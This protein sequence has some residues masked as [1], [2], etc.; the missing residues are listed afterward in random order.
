[1]CYRIITVCH[2]VI[3]V[4]Q[5]IFTE[6]YCV[7]TA[8]QHIIIV[9]C[10]VITA[11]PCHNRVL[12]RHHCEL[13]A[14]CWFTHVSAPSL[15]ELCL[16]DSVSTSLCVNAAC[17][18]HFVSSALHVNVTLCQQRCAPISLWF[19]NTAYQHLLRRRCIITTL[20]VNISVFKYH[21][22]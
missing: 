18:H 15:C 5:C 13:A 8:C 11:S 16:Y 10:H 21:C 3:T 22:I 12:V 19:N 6:C 9:C 17:Q 2:R 1:M 7:I 20:C 4:C 14:V